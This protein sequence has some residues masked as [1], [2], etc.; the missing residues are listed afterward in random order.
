MANNLW[1]GVTGPGAWGDADMLEAGNPGLSKVLK[2]D[3][4][5][6]SLLSMSMLLSTVASQR[7][8]NRTLDGS[9]VSLRRCD[10]ASPV[11]AFETPAGPQLKLQRQ[12]AC[13]AVDLGAAWRP[14]PM[15]QGS[16]A[17]SV[18]C[19][20]ATA[21]RMAKSGGG[22]VQ[23]AVSSDLELCF[24]FRDNPGFRE[25]IST[26]LS[27]CGSAN[28]TQ[29]KLVAASGRLVHKA[30]GMCVEA[31]LPPMANAYWP[32]T[33]PCA[34]AMASKP[35]C[36]VTSSIDARVAALVAELTMDEKLCL[37]GG[38]DFATGFGMTIT[39][40]VERLGISSNQ[41]WHEALHGVAGCPSG[42]KSKQTSFPAAIGMAGSFN[43]SLFHLVGAA[44]GT[45][46]QALSS[47]FNG[48]TFF[49]P[50]VNTIHDVWQL[51]AC[52]VAAIA[53]ASVACVLVLTPFPS[54]ATLGP[55][56]GNARR[57]PDSF[58]CVRL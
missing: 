30:S 47:R 26:Q 53:S 55:W 48:G 33:N 58:V 3:D 45:E 23:L 46:A 9:A 41:W 34:G 42:C 52:T 1:A 40:G 17:W 54:S 37:F 56:T 57:R 5:I 24:G 51:L 6:V 16:R 35:W 13:V 27:E 39:C 18:I 31:G 38:P 43:R 29:F 28:E 14:T 22:I 2:A 21:W 19:A 25:G 7:G 11:M 10:A 44:I 4:R 49:T 36:S 12:D 20:N 50:N 32:R 8:D 15:A